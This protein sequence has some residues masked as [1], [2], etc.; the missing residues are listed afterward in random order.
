[1]VTLGGLLVCRDVEE[2]EL[3]AAL[4]PAHVAR[5]RAEPGCLRFEVD[6]TDDP[7]VWTVAERF[8]DA[9]S[10]RAHQARVAASDWGRATA[11]IE[12]RYTVSGLD[13]E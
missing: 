3:V 4:L 5:T 2:S 1:M 7:L 6:A 10:F 9:T 12:R 11:A 13:P 8:S